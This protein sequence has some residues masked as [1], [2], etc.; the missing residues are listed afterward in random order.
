MKLKNISFRLK[1]NDLRPAFICED[2]KDIEISNW[3]IPATHGAQSIIRL[4]NI[5]GAVINSNRIKG[6]ASAF[7][8][9]EGTNS[10]TVK[11]LKNQTPGIKKE[12]ESV[13]AV[14]REVAVSDKDDK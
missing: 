5:E 2:G 1:N 7:V 6:T 9:V 4:E 10:K 11:L 3:N 14:K 13:P 8:R 12:V